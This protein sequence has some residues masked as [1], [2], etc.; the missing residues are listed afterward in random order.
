MSE[1]LKESVRQFWNAQACG[2][3]YAEGESPAE[4]L[5]RQA[6]ERYILEPGIHQ[7]A[8]FTGGAGRDVLE[9]GV[10]MGADHL[11]WAKSAPRSLTGIDLTERGI[12]LTQERL[13]YYGLHS[14]LRIADAENLPFAAESFD[15]VYSYGVLHHSPDTAQA[16]REVWR[17]LRPGGSARIMIYH[18]PSVV[19]YMLWLRYGL[20]AGKPLR[21]LRDI[22]A[23]HL[24]S[25]GTK[26]FSVSEARAML[27]SF[28]SVD[29][30]I[31][32]GPGDLLEGAV[33]QRHRGV[34]LGIAKALWPRWFIRS[35]MKK[36]GLG[37]LIAA[38]K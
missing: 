16:I 15:I 1:T 33:G 24:E 4:K 19:G 34:L 27:S 10:D 7:F 21:S 38:S 6:R 2:E 23:R 14:D 20:F 9:I 13:A 28:S 32:L 18:S 11:E 30:R 29:T 22:Y 17:V 35:A 3:V 31:V 36:H 37:M 12:Q 26:A 8:G 5:E 25:P